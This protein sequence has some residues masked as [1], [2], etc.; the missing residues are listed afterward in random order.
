MHSQF[1]A[2]YGGLLDGAKIQKECNY[3]LLKSTMAK[4]ECMAADAAGDEQLAMRD[5]AGISGPEI[6]ELQNVMGQAFE[7][8]KARWSEKQET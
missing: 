4:V 7:N 5:L 6:V 8:L 1:A 2:T 3:D